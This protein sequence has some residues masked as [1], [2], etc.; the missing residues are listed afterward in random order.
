MALE[1]VTVPCRS[2][3]YAYLVHNAQTDETAIVDAPEASP[4]L[5]ALDAKGWTPSSVFITHHHGD[6]VE[7]LPGIQKKHDVKLIGAAADARRLPKLDLA[8]SENDQIDMCGHSAQIFD[9]S[10]HTI[11]HIAI[12]VPDA[13]AV[14]TADS[15][16]ALG[17]GRVFEGTM[18]QMWTS[19]SKLAALPPETVVYSGHEYTAANAKFALTIEPDNA[20]LLARVKEISEK[21]AKSVPTVPSKLSTELATNPFL[22]AAD[23]NVRKS[24]GLEQAT[25]AEV[26]AEIRT[27]KDSF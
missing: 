5:D 15:L 21:R 11:G 24:L 6:H 27:R 12:Y 16:M 19:L 22:R 7:G 3:N 9:V 13:K 14:F 18:E 8:V 17:C 10:G 2:D 20:D 25:D 23:P 4:L 1:I 26:F